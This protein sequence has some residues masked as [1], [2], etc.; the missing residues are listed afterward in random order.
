MA[1]IEDQ[2]ISKLFVNNVDIDESLW[3]EGEIFFS[4]FYDKNDLFLIYFSTDECGSCFRLKPQLKRLVKETEIPLIA[5][6]INE[7]RDLFE[8]RN[9]NGV[10]VVMLFRGK[11]E[12]KTWHGYHGRSKYK[13]FI[14]N[15]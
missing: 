14:N 5:I 2:D 6:N 7:E 15:L 11:E 13:E 12:L 1:N 10:P 4:E 8:S 3:K 9:F